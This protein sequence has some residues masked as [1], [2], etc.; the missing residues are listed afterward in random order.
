VCC[1]LF[2]VLLIEFAFGL[3]FFV[4]DTLDPGEVI[5]LSLV[6]VVELEGS[7]ECDFPFCEELLD[8]GAVVIGDLEE[9][10]LELGFEL[11]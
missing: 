8:A 11:L 7:V 6:I 2:L 4:L 9:V 10:L 3:E 5:L 1:F